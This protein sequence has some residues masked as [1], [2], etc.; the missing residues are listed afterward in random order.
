MFTSEDFYCGIDLD[1][2]VEEP[3]GKLQ[4]WAQ[5]IV[6]K[7]DSYT[8]YSPSGLGVHIIIKGKKKWD[9]C[10]INLKESSTANESKKPAIEVYD[11]G[12][13]FYGNW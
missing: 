8:E 11:Q 3:R 9:K 2:A 6:D 5:E 7:F 4:P 1:V 10:K 12:R 13:F